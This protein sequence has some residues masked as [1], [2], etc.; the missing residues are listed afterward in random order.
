MRNAVRESCI[1]TRALPGYC[2]SPVATFNYDG[3]K[4]SLYKL[5]FSKSVEFVSVFGYNSPCD[6]ILKELH[7]LYETLLLKDITAV[8][9]INRKDQCIC[10]LNTSINQNTATNHTFILLKLDAVLSSYHS[11]S[12]TSSRYSVLF[13]F[14]LGMVSTVAAMTYFSKR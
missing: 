2:E 13:S 9:L 3:T 10:L 6:S 14:A 11:G 5:E 4:Q 1:F 8:Y 12:L 7:Y